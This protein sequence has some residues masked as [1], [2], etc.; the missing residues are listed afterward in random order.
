MQN[1]TRLKIVQSRL[2]LDGVITHA[3]KK[4]RKPEMG[5]IV[6]ILKENWGKRH[7]IPKGVWLVFLAYSL[8]AFGSPMPPKIT[9]LE[10][11]MGC[12]LLM[13]GIA[14]A[15]PAIQKIRHEKSAMWC[16]GLTTSLFFI[17]L[18][19]GLMRGNA[20]SDMMRDIFPFLFLIAIPFLLV[21]STPPTGRVAVS[22]L[23]ATALVFVGI[24]TAITF[25]WDSLNL[26]GSAEQM[27]SSTRNY[28]AQISEAQTAQTAQTADYEKMRAYFLKPYD[29]AM[30]FT[31]IFLSAWG[32]V[33]MVRSWRGWLPGM[34]L[35]GMGALIAYG[36]MILGLR[37]YTAFFAVSILTMCLYMLRKR[38]LYV[39]FM[40]IVLV[41]CA[42]LWPQI[43]AVMQLLWAKQHTIGS[44]GKVGE[45]LA[46]V[47][48]IYATPQT[49]LFGIGWGGILENPIYLNETTRF[50]HS[51]LSFYLL[52]TGVIGLGILLTVIGL[53][54]TYFQKTRGGNRLDISGLILLVSCTPPLLIG[55]L[56]QPTYKILSYGVI[57]TLLILTLPSFWKRAQ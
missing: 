15:G 54:L 4:Q 53:L 51:V 22:A 28:F 43:E 55:V 12:G 26:F 21:Y 18:C 9:W 2:T 50:T 57:L 45:W 39:R 30:L 16:L 13:G 47:T 36:F 23:I 35:V 10:I 7:L 52:K 20:L 19:I 17:P 41:A 8:V 25:F 32:M 56:F 34:F 5:S 46:V 37:A 24:C 27:V 3:F 31:A 44:N 33:L 40:P 48:T 6:A 14:L 42:V 38:G 49:M 1:F 11:V 29:P